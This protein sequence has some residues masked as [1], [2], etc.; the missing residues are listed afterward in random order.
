MSE[1]YLGKKRGKWTYSAWCKGC[2][3]MYMKDRYRDIIPKSGE[4]YFMRG[5]TYIKTKSN[6]YKILWTEQMLN[7]L[8]VM[9]DSGITYKRISHY[10]GPSEESCRK[11]Y[12]EIKA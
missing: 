6:S 9:R 3:R 2:T 12:L 4:E 1:Y 8:A 7:A 11:K 10:L 5:L